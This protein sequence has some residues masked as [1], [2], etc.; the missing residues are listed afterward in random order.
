MLA[1][2]DAAGG[3]AIVTADHGNAETMIDPVTGGPHTAH[4]LNVVPIVV[5]RAPAGSVAALAD[6]RLSDVAPTLLEL[7]G[8]PVPPSMTG[9]SLI[10]SGGPSPS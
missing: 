5:C 10:A 1:A 2:L 7:M 8:L 4:T 3:A 6:G 9:R